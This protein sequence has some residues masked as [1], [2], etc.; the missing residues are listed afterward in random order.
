MAKGQK[1]G[2]VLADLKSISGVVPESVKIQTSYFW[3]NKIPTKRE[4]V[5]IILEGEDQPA[6]EEEEKTDQNQGQEGEE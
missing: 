6:R 3:V 2:R 1:T 4:K 5:K